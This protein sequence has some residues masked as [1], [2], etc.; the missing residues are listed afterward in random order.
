MGNPTGCPSM[1]P[2]AG[3]PTPPRLPSGGSSKVTLDFPRT[4]EPA[5]SRPGREIPAAAPPNC[6]P[7]WL[8]PAAPAAPA[9]PPP[10]EWGWGLL[11]ARSRIL[12]Y[13]ASWS[14]AI[15]LPKSFLKMV[16]SAL[17]TEPALSLSLPIM[18]AVP[19]P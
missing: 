15:S 8:A 1:P 18:V 7:V 10:G 3:R 9:A 4:G 5:A 14:C 13:R 11:A 6:G 12:L 19:F 16:K 2:P 17:D